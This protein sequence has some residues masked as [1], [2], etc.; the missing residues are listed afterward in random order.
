[1]VSHGCIWLLVVAWSV[2]NITYIYIYLYNVRFLKTSEGI[3]ER[4]GFA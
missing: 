1:M 4:Q 3:I 2:R